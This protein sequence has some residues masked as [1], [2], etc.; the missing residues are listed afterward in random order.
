MTQPIHPDRSAAAASD[1]D[2]AVP[3]RAD[4]ASRPAP[5]DDDAPPASPAAAPR[6]TADIAQGSALL[7]AVDR[8][9]APNTSIDS[10]AVAARA[11]ARVAELLRAEP[12]R[13][14]QAYAGLGRD[15]VQ[16]L[17]TTA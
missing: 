17:L 2:R 12:A 7:R 6:D 1:R 9:D 10:A 11:T 3:I 5:R 8:R 13:A 16:A 14:M 4:A 15:D